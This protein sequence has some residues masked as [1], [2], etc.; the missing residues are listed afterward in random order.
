MIKHKSLAGESFNLISHTHSGVKTVAYSSKNPTN[1]ALGVFF[2]HLCK[3]QTQEK[4]WQLEQ[5]P[6]YYI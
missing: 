4:H 2:L 5:S 6:M 1:C 3:A